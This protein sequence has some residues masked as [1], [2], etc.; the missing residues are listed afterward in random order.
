MSEIEWGFPGPVA[1][2]Y[3][4]VNP[5]DLGITSTDP[6]ELG[7]QFAV[8]LNLWMQGLAAGRKIDVVPNAQEPLAGAPEDLTSKKNLEALS[9]EDAQKIISD[10]LK[11]TAP[12][13]EDVTQE[14]KPWEKK[15]VAEVKISSSIMDDF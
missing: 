13:E 1:Y 14:R 5:K 7:V 11:E 10:G 12:W 4:H 15:P 9:H 3:M 8:Q 6:Y 2:S